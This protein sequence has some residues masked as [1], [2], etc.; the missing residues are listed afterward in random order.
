V[1][2]AQ[3]LD[4]LVFIAGCDKIVPGMAM[5]AARLDLPCVFVTA[6]ATLC[7]RYKGKKFAGGYMVREAAHK[8]INGEVSLEEYEEMEKSVLMGPGSCPSMETANTMCTLMEHIGLALPGSGTTHAVY[9]KKLRQARESGRLVMQLLKK[10][11]RPSDYI[12]FESFRN[13][14]VM[15]M[16]V[17]GSTNSMIHLPAI[18]R[19]FGIELTPDFF[20]EISKNTPHLANV[21]PSGSYT[22]LDIEEAGGTIAIAAE[23][24]DLLNPD[25]KAVTQETWGE[26]VKGHNSE[27]TDA[28]RTRENPL[29]EQGSIAI[30]KGTLAPGYA[31]VKQ[32]AVSPKMMVHKGPAVVF[33]SEEDTIAGIQEGKVLRGSVIVLRYE[34]P[35][36]GPGMREM[37]AA[38]TQLLGYGLGDSV[39]LVTDGR[40]SGATRGPCI[41]HISAEAAVG[42]PIAFV[43]DGDIISID[44]PNGILDLEV[45]SEEL[46]KRKENW[47]PK[48]IEKSNSYLYRYSKMVGDVWK[49]AKMD[50]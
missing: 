26:I 21:L 1:V 33:E 25:V 29:H 2:E 40:F 5:A 35:K 4:A 45:S 27:N 46:A 28:I 30:L 20:N 6:G 43:K 38:T 24:K 37:L 15:D 44:I 16:A 9:T 31:C 32:S 7:G 18:A 23:L 3:R 36:G 19:E 47:I 49:G 14:T 39:A 48:Q 12:N 10:N 34:G 50:F 22:M 42:G 11:I 13:A 17:G 8:L 41:G